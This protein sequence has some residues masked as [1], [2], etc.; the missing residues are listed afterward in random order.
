MS[1]V[2][3]RLE[4]KGL[5][6]PEPLKIPRG[7]DLPF[8]WVSLR[9]NR[10]F[11]SGHGPQNRDGSISGPFGQVGA[12][13]SVEDAR[14]LAEKTA[15]A[16]LTSLENELGDL[17]RIVGWCRVFGMV[18]SAPGFNRQP[19]VI[20]GFTGIITSV[21]DADVARHTR[22]AVGM[23]ALPFNIAVEIEGEVLIAV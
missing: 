1:K 11:I 3:N 5:V 21:F 14:Q 19:A 22:S 10:A 9:G 7:V 4:A 13:V 23:A 15:L 8:P 20:N 16:I 2:R 6:L 12:D 18:N 17:D